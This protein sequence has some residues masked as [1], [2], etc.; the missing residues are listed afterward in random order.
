MPNPWDV[1]SARFLAGM[2]FPALATT[3]AGH[4]FTLGRRDQQVTRDEL[5]R[6]VDDLASAVDV[7]LN[8][9]S[10]SCFP[11]DPGGVTETAR[12]LSLTGAA[13]FSIEDFDSTEGAVLPL[14]R[15]QGACGSGCRGRQCFGNDSDRS[16]RKPHLRDQ[17]PR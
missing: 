14:A 12:L 13:G 6:H 9:D 10:E 4:A 8:V 16:R 1:G 3:S 7:P 17:Q 11:H 2:G 15:A 5:L